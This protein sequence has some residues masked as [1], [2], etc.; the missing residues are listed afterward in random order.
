M[1][2]TKTKTGQRN[3]FRLFDNEHGNRKVGGQEYGFQYG[4][5]AELQPG[6]FLSQIEF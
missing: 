5:K 6:L 2:S 3:L 1:M 4:S